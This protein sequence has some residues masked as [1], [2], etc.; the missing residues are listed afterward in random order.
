MDPKNNGDPKKNDDPKNNGENNLDP[1]NINDL[2]IN[3]NPEKNDDPE[4]SCVPELMGDPCML[5]KHVEADE[6]SWSNE[7]YIKSRPIKP[8]SELF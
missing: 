4:I 8:W 5:L 1:K 7:I 3:G 2:K 6:I